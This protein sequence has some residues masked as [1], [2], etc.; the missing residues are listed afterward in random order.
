MKLNGWQRT[1]IIATVVWIPCMFFHTLDQEQVGQAQT[2]SAIR[3]SCIDSGQDLY[4]CDKV[5]LD[6]LNRDFKRERT[7]AL[8]KTFVPIPFMWLGAYAILGLIRW[9]KR[10]FAP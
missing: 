5:Y 2:Y 10:G 8:L 7:E 9:V 3:K 4:E 6:G 1:G